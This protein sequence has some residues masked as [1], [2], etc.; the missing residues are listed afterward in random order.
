MGCVSQY[1]RSVIT[2]AYTYVHTGSTDGIDSYIINV[3]KVI[4]I[5]RMYV[6]TNMNS[7]VS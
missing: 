6:D 5:R 4:A 7:I 2:Y 3:N 1:W